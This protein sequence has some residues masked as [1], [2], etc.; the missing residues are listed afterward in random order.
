MADDTLESNIVIKTKV[1]RPNREGFKVIHDDLDRLNKKL[2]DLTSKPWMIKLQVDDSALKKYGLA[3]NQTP[4][5][6]G[7]QPPRGPGGPFPS[8]SGGQG[9]PYY[10]RTAETPNSITYT[11]KTRSRQGNTQ[12]T[13]T[14]T[15][16]DR[17]KYVKEE[18][19]LTEKLNKA[20]ENLIN[21]QKKRYDRRNASAY[22]KEKNDEVKLL[23]RMDT[24]E[25]AVE[26]ASRTRRDRRQAR[27]YFKQQVTDP[28]RQAKRDQDS[29]YEAGFRRDRREAREHFRDQVTNPERE[30]RINSERAQR[31]RLR[32]ARRQAAT[33][34]VNGRFT[35][36]LGQGFVAQ[37]S[38]RQYNSRTGEWSEIRNAV[39]TTGN[40][41]T[42]YT[43]EVLR[44]N[45][46]T[47]KL[48][49][50]TLNG[51][52][53]MRYLGDNVVRAVAKVSL[54]SLATSAVFGAVA[55]IKYA[56][57]EVAKLE[58]Q[59][60]L[61]A[62]VGSNFAGGS[63]EF[64]DRYEAADK[65][66]KQLI[67]LTQVYGGN[68]T[69]AQRAA[70]IF[71]RSGRDEQETLHATRA[72]L[73]AARIAELEVEDAAKLLSAAM[74][75]FNLK[76]QQLLPTL[77]ALNTLSNQYRVTT[78][79][80]L[81]AISRTGSVYADH[82]GRLTELAA[83]TAV[84]AQVTAR[85]G[86]EIGNAFKT[87]SSNL[88]RVD[89]QQLILERLGVSTVN[90]EG[91]AKSLGTVLFELRN[92]FDS[93]SETQ[94]KQLTLQIAGV[95]QRNALVA[96]IKNV[97]DAII[98]EN[99]A[100]LQSGSASEEF[101]QSS[102]TLTASLQRLKATL[103]SV[104]ADAGDVLLPLV[105]GFINL[106]DVTL[107]V[108]TLM[109]GLPAKALAAAGAF[110]VLARALVACGV[111]T[112]IFNRQLLASAALLGIAII[113][114]GLV[115]RNYTTYSAAIDSNIDIINS[116]IEAERNKRTAITN[117]ANAVLHLVKRYNEL[118][119]AGKDAEAEE[120]KKRGMNLAGSAGLGIG[121]FTPE[122]VASSAVTAQQ[123]SIRKERQKL[124][125]LAAAQR[126]NLSEATAKRGEAFNNA[127]GGRTWEE[128]FSGEGFHLDQEYYG[129]KRGRELD[130]AEAERKKAAQEVKDTEQKIADLKA[131]EL[132]DVVKLKAYEDALNALYKD[133]LRAEERVREAKLSSVKDTVDSKGSYS[134]QEEA[135]ANIAKDSDEAARN[136]SDMLDIAEKMGQAEN[137]ADDVKRVN[138]LYDDRIDQFKK[139]LELQIQASQKAVSGVY[140][141]H[142]KLAEG[143]ALIGLEKE[144][145]LGNASTYGDKIAEI[146]IRR[147]VQSERITNARKGIEEAEKFK[148][149][150]P[151]E[152]AGAI[153]AAREDEQAAITNLKDLEAE[154]ALAILDAEKNIAIERKK[155]AD[156]A[157]RAL[158]SLSSEDKLRVRA[159]AAYFAKNPGAKVSLEDQ[160]NMDEGSGRVLGQFFQS[161]QETLTD[162]KGRLADS[163]RGA[164]FGLTEDLVKGGAEIDVARRGRTDKEILDDA[165]NRSTDLE[166]GLAGSRGVPIP[167][168]GAFA[169]PF[170]VG[171]GVTKD[172]RIDTNIPVE[173]KGDTINFQPMIDSFEKVATEIMDQKVKEIAEEVR[174]IADEQRALSNRSRPQRYGGNASQ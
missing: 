129:K 20:E 154:K 111:A 165:Q 139:L 41:F 149:D 174:K 113:A 133:R 132:T 7:N 99:K 150:R 63:N 55:A 94:Q 62:R 96:A 21:A 69:E 167:G 51:S 107:R 38:T 75:Q 48:Q 49:V 31:D 164:G 91:D 170:D 92:R 158:G 95:R 104:A 70:A 117:T 84:V 30:A 15:S 123:S 101:L 152:A 26:E 59:T 85:S 168:L 166:R 127:S 160:F 67:E 40:A 80:L 106:V 146:D 43:V 172:G 108:L 65:L 6:G 18:L 46:A 118:K 142:N 83:L 114:L 22:L 122:G 14:F 79:D 52:R 137:Y 173:I 147:R 102:I 66:T 128:I 126:Q 56:S 151:A 44:A 134:R 88:D 78:D 136:L 156:E 169:R 73:I 24:R 97:D 8:Y 135:Y 148:I 124:E 10:R 121:T 163:L 3:Q 141:T 125:E 81:Q 47:G 120:T 39:R 11:E 42:G 17:T 58:E 25:A 110:Y 87:I 157:A 93:L 45:Q 119:E 9:N 112:T 1:A 105:K 13:E 161:H 155:S 153:N 27:E 36:M 103:V 71:A 5:S 77:D 29:I 74:L 131:Q 35:S 33:G 115:A 86:S 37:P 144:R 138:K 4:V 159:Q 68:A 82:N 100:L 90:F 143:S 140:A 61:L 19:D 54:W 116:S 2:V 28:E 57:Q 12:T 162:A 98:A 171:G 34:D 16:G 60:V 53:A 130:A 50:E 109:N 23:E 64:R 32:E 145:R 76:G 89:T 72:A